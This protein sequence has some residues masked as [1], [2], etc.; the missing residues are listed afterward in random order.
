MP[1]ISSAADLMLGGMIADVMGQYPT[2]PTVTAVTF[3]P[4]LIMVSDP[5]QVMHDD[6]QTHSMVNGCLHMYW[7]YGKVQ[8]AVRTK[9][10]FCCCAE[11]YTW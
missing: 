2:A 3:K 11:H 8:L 1:S 6:M 9:R 4:A 5:V 10:S 7:A